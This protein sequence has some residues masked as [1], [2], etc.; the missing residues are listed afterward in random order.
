MFRKPIRS[1]GIVKVIKAAMD[2]LT[3]SIEIVIWWCSSYAALQKI[4]ENTQDVPS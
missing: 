4:L 1:E 3:E 2:L